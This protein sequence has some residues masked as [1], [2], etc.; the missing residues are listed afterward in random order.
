MA[1][2]PLVPAN[3][4]LPDYFRHR[5]GSSVGRQRVMQF[6]S[7]L[8]IVVH[9]VPESQET[10][11]RGILIWRDAEGKW[12]ASSGEIGSSAL[13]SLIKRYSKKLAEFDQLESKAQKSDEYLPL[14]E[15]LSPVLR[16]VRNLY[17]VLQ[18]ARKLCPDIR[19]LIEVRDY[20]YDVSRT[21]EL[22]Y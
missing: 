14:L 19:E 8:L 9:Q 13:E 6:E 2:A 12:L 4:Q 7:Q 18:E 17:D 15:G 21:A 22:L 10:Q 3:W 16:S 20:A 11:R 5:L 1:H